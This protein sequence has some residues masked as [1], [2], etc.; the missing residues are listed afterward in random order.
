MGSYP[1]HERYRA[2]YARYH[3]RGV[4]ELLRLLIPLNGADVADLCGGDGRL[5]SEILASGARHV[6]FVDAE[7]RMVPETIRKHERVIVMIEEVHVALTKIIENEHLLD[8]IVCQQAVN[9]W[10]NEETAIA[11]ANALKPGGIF[12]FNTFNQKP[13]EKPRVLEYELGGGAFVEISWLVGEIVHHVQIR[14]G[15]SPH[16]TAFLWLSPEKIRGLLEPYFVIDEDRH[17]KTS[18]YRCE[19]K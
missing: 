1:D 19:K 9:Y 3:E 15:L 17:K 4:A 11:V 16:E 2:L 12:A 14:D 5:T 7:S 10:L 6:V 18:L 8:R 13:S